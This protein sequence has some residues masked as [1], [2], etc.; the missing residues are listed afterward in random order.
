MTDS[1]SLRLDSIHLSRRMSRRLR[2]DLDDFF[3]EI[4]DDSDD[5][6]V[7]FL[8]QAHRNAPIPAPLPA[9]RPPLRARQPPAKRARLEDIDALVDADALPGGLSVKREPTEGNDNLSSDPVVVPLDAPRPPA[10]YYYDADLGCRMFRGSGYERFPI[11][12]GTV[13]GHQNICDDWDQGKPGG[14]EIDHP[15]Q[16]TRDVLEAVL[17]VLPD[18]EHDF[19]RQEIVRLSNHNTLAA[20][21][22]ALVISQVLDLQDYPRRK[23]QAKRAVPEA[24]A[25]GT[26]ITIIA[27]GDEQLHRHDY[28]KRAIVL[29][30]H[31]FRHVPTRY[32]AKWFS[33]STNP[34]GRSLHDGYLHLTEIEAKYYVL[35]E[36]PY[37]R[38]RQP[39]QTV[40]K[41]YAV[42]WPPQGHA[43][44]LMVNEI[45]AAKQKLEREAIKHS[46]DAEL[47]DNEAANLEQHRL[48]N[49][50]IE[51]Q[52]CFD[53]EIPL[54]RAVACDGE[55]AH[56]FCYG[57][58]CQLASTQVGMMKHEMLCM[59]Q[60]GC[61]AD[62]NANGV[63]K[64]VPRK[65]L[66]RL[67]LNQQQADIAAAGIEGLEQCPHCEFK[68]VLDPVELLAV[69]Q[70]FNPECRR[71]TCRKCHEDAHVPKSCE[72]VKKDRGLSARHR[73]E[74]ARTESMLRP[75]PKC[76]VKIIKDIGC[77]KMVCRCG[78]MICYV[79]KAD[80]TQ[81][82]Y[83]HFHSGK[84]PLHDD[85]GG[86]ARRH[87]AEANEAERKAIAAAREEDGDLDED[88]LRIETK[89]GDQD[90]PE[91]TR[92]EANGRRHARVGLPPIRDRIQ[93]QMRAMRDQHDQ[94]RA[95]ADQQIDRMR[96]ELGQRRNAGPIARPLQDQQRPF[97][98]DP[99]QMYQIPGN[100]DHNAGA[101]LLP[102]AG[103]EPA[104]GV[105]NP[106]FQPFAAPA[107]PRP[108]QP[109]DR[110]QG[111]GLHY[112]AIHA[113]PQ[114]PI[115]GTHGILR[116]ATPAVPAFPMNAHRG[117]VNRAA[118][119]PPQDPYFGDVGP[120]LL[121]DFDFDV[122][123]RGDPLMEQ[124]VLAEHRQRVE[125]MED[126]FNGAINR[127][128]WGPGDNNRPHAAHQ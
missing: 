29:L 40:E 95:A 25:D 67:A 88:L 12:L 98:G 78:C 118:A 83:N 20:V 85:A 51:C 43:H 127:V 100:R 54:N 47:A 57:C 10:P 70:C 42:A 34:P 24:A 28:S 36:K 44:L 122:F 76:K 55:V 113:A 114:A 56:F 60:S 71:T 117:P 107:Q 66:D 65:I 48:N 23:P 115:G 99:Y 103:A 112:I 32:I 30:A 15:D 120:N 38:L 125:R 6:S 22:P 102:P 26:G 94:L 87:D 17:E 121:E 37:K 105:A 111:P 93:D 7:I 45:Q 92:P 91:P 46:N 90:A 21:T 109:A 73:V 86:I 72:E 108:L 5:D 124:E 63:G 59:H 62:L 52:V 41:K 110:A 2:E 68:A 106:P 50:L 35:K 4:S 14:I 27:R 69:F 64:A 53:D 77:N 49:D 97:A 31:Q 74:E 3:V 1:L 18:I 123:L 81:S 39:R 82:G 104:F 128:N 16:H 126:W 96:M 61:K 116:P 11:A 84:C 80:I 101:I 89:A 9:H 8:G 33:E 58:V 19:V 13:D 79:C 119:Q 75:C